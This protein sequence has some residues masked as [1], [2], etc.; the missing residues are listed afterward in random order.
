MGAVHGVSFKYVGLAGVAA[1]AARWMTPSDMDRLLF[2]DDADLSGLYNIQLLF[3]LYLYNVSFINLVIAILFNLQLGMGIL[4][5]DPVSGSIPIWSYV[6]FFGFHGPTY[7]YTKIQRERDRRSGVAPADEV[8]PGWWVGGRYSHELGKR[9][10][11]TIDLTCEFPETSTQEKYLLVECWDGVPPSPEQLEEAAQFS[12]AAHERGD[13]LVHCA[14]GRG[15]S[16]TTLCACLVRAGR[17][18]T[19]E[20]AFAAI[21]QKRRVVKLNRSMRRALTEWQ[22][23]YSTKVK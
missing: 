3:V 17:Y 15:R 7:F 2:A 22:A 12:I 16:T 9:W 8:E 11:G 6:L 20:D 23:K 13:V 10:A 5:K 4:G 21:K 19:W 18:P 1:A 14:H